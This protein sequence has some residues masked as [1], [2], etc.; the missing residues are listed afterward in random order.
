MLEKQKESPRRPRISSLGKHALVI[1]MKTLVTEID[2]DEAEYLAQQEQ[3]PPKNKV[4]SVAI[5]PWLT[6]S[7]GIDLLRGCSRQTIVLRKIRGHSLARVSV[8]VVEIKFISLPGMC[9]KGPTSTP[10][11]VRNCG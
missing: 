10:S 2:Q 5:G 6:V 11:S 9:E 1:C 3:N 7:S 8:F 4:N